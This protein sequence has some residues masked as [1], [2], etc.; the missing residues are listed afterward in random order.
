MSKKHCNNVL[1]RI[2]TV[3][4][5]YE[6]VPAFNEIC[7]KPYA[8]SNSL[9]GYSHLPSCWKLGCKHY[10][11]I[12]LNCTFITQNTS[13]VYFDSK[14][15]LW[16]F[17]TILSSKLVSLTHRNISYKRNK[18]KSAVNYLQW[19]SARGAIERQ[20]IR[21]YY[22]VR[23][24]DCVVPMKS[25]QILSNFF[26]NCFISSQLPRIFDLSKFNISLYRFLLK[27]F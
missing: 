6:N 18:L 11:G 27:K 9:Y 4:C 17:S 16:R 3:L 24:L 23:C 10:R 22:W 2:R 20:L 13:R 7:Y 15:C 12:G 8:L 5:I 19:T 26:Y 1:T 21:L 14:T 25:L